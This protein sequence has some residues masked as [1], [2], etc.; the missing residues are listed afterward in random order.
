M[1]KKISFNLLCRW[2]FP[3]SQGGVAMH[4]KNLV[5][6][7]LHSMN[8]RQISLHNIENKEYFDFA[9][10]PFDAIEQPKKIPHFL[11]KSQIINNSYRFFIDKYISDK[12]SHL[13]FI[14]NPDV[15]EFM[16]IN[17]EAFSFLKKN[18]IS[19][20]NNP[21]VVI[22]SH[23]PWGLLR[24]FFRKKSRNI[25]EAWGAIK[26]EKFCF[27]KCNAIT[28]P[29]DS[30]K[31][32]LIEIYNIQPEKIEVIPNIIDTNIFKPNRNIVKDNKIFNILHVGRLDQSKGVLTLIRAFVILSK[33]YKNITL[34]C[35]GKIVEKTKGNYQNILKN[36]N[37]SD[38][39]NF[40]K[41]IPYENLSDEYS[42]AD[43][44]VVPSEI[45]ESF[46]YTVAQG[47]SCEKIVI[48]SNIGGIPETLKFGELG[49]MFNPGNIKELADSIEEVLINKDNYKIIEKAARKYV[50]KNF[51]SSALKE[52][53]LKFYQSIIKVQN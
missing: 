44:V 23:T 42:K 21:K 33:K 4:N 35:V 19:T 29:S 51:S 18:N 48:G 13:I 36:E 41:F 1:N 17:S 40:K 12:M 3:I 39:V 22:R 26:K 49:K 45:Y 37:L 8:I 16:D 28:V 14:N 15:V 32:N 25:V 20:K 24:P 30:L 38:K 27:D 46:S 11:L 7:L 9:N 50:V 43:V 53:Y 2:A 31:T 5:D 6:T 52:R 47:M 10:V 34:T